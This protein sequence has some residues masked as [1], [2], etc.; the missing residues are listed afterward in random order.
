MNITVAICT[1]N[2]APLLDQTLAQL[3]RLAVPDGVTWELLV[4]NNRCTDDTDAVLGRHAGG[5][6]L[7]RLFE[8]APGLSNARNC[9]QS[10]SRGDY[11]IWTDDDVLADPTWLAEYCA[12]FRRWP[13]AA[14]FAGFVE[15]W[16]EAPP[17]EAMARAFEALAVGY[18]GIDWGPKER[19]LR[20]EESPKGANMAYRRALVQHLRF[21]PDLGMKADQALFGEE[22]AYCDRLTAAGHHGVWVPG[23]RV[24]HFVPAKRMELAYLKNF[25]RGLG[26]IIVRTGNLAGGPRLAGVPRWV[27]R[28]YGGALCARA[29][30]RLGRDKVAYYK[31]LAD[32]WRLEGIIRECRDAGRAAAPKP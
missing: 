7:R 11:L 5:L 17:P 24:K 30:R 3:G 32:Q 10:E 2:R 13:D 1:Y 21:D 23:A 25:Y 19:V 6:P 27:L 31:T 18:C 9:A 29:W 14:Y 16:F 4:V 12:A 28:K 26:R 22:T 8:P 15:P 20:P